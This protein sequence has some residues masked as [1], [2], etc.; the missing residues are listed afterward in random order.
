MKHSLPI[1]YAMKRKKMAKGG[2]VDSARR[3][4]Q[5]NIDDN[6]AHLIAPM[7]AEEAAERM[8][9]YQSTSDDG[10]VDR[11]MKKRGYAQGGLVANEPGEKAGEKS[12]DFDYLSV[13]DLDDSST[14]SGASSGDFL[15]NEQEDQDRKDIVALIM[16]KRA[17]QQNP[18][19]V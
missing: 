5:H 17:K 1:A 15:G 7:T 10:I 3:K 11:I 12:A 19:P 6:D 16:R 2:M 13:G 18:S 4:A 8:D 9:D 14:N